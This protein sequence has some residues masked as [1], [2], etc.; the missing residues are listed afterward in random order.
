V[1]GATLRA[2]I[3]DPNVSVKARIRWLIDVGRALA[4]AHTAGLVHRDIK[5]E[6][7]M[8]REDGVAKVLD[9][10][11]AKRTT[12]L[13][14]D[15]TSSTEGYIV[16]TSTAVGAIVGTPLYMAPEQMRAETLDGRADQFAWGVVAYELL[17]GKPP[18]TVDAGPVALI[19]QILAS[20][21]K[22]LEETSE[23]PAYVIDA[24]MRTLSKGRGDRFASMDEVVEAIGG[25]PDVNAATLPRMVVSN[26]VMPRSTGNEPT[27]PLPAPAPS[28][29]TA[30]PPCGRMRVAVG[31]HRRR[32]PPGL[33]G[34]EPCSITTSAGR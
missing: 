14:V 31:D 10:G 9:F 29:H 23:L 26:R 22:R 34:R 24:V 18:W 7:V 25:P 16:P 5:P 6:N 12:E 8:V 4:A 11:V 15:G 21:P 13:P 33:T 1:K 28:T 20:E 17:S 3:G 19:G 30:E 27:V 32:P 2:F